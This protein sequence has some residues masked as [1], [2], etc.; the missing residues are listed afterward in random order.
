MNHVSKSVNLHQ[1]QIDE[2]ELLYMCFFMEKYIV[3]IVFDLCS[4]LGINI[5]VKRVNTWSL[6]VKATPSS[7]LGSLPGKIP[8]DNN[9]Q[10]FQK[11]KY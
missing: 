3:Q 4:V 5:L 9:E 11:H 2:M 1:H 10:I 7:L 8:F 6:F